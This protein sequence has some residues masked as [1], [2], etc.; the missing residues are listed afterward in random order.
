M[1]EWTNDRQRVQGNIEKNREKTGLYHEIRQF[2]NRW[3]QCK[4]MWTFHE[5]TLNNTGFGRNANGTVIADDD[6]WN[7]HTKVL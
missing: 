7:K 3:T 2:K 5:M 1:P 4:S 6:W